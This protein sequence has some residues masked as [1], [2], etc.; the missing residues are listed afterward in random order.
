MENGRHLLDRSVCRETFLCTQV[1]PT[2]ALSIVGSNVTV[3]EVLKEVVRDR[4]FYE[5]SGGGVTF[6]GGEPTMQPEFLRALVKAVKQQ[7][8]HTALETS[9][10]CSYDILN[11]LL[12]EVDLFLYDW[13]ET[14]PIKHKAY[15]GV[16]NTLI[17]KNLLQLHEDGASILL[18][19]PVI[20]G[21]NDTSEHFQGIAELSALLPNLMGVEVLP[22]HRLAASKS[23]RM[24]LQAQELYE[25]PSSELKKLWNEDLLRRGAPVLEA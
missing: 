2:Q 16:D 6:S 5:T 18:R 8:L 22:Y 25:L 21:L 12:P 20:C 17:R 15:T 9:G 23:G 11:S 7:G 4:K 1:C 14:D 19:C 13:K 10:F 3:D 24:G